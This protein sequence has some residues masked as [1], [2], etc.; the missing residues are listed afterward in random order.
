MVKVL[1][2][3][4]FKNKASNP[5]NYLLYKGIEKEG[6]DVQEFSFKRL[7]LMRYDIV[8]I[9]WP[10]LYLNSHYLSKAILYNVMLILGL[11]L[12]KCFNK[13]TVWTVHNLK[14]HKIKYQR[15]NKLFWRCYL[16]LVDSVISLSKSNE[17]LF[18]EKFS[19]K[20]KLNS[21]VVY[22]GLY[23]GYYENNISKDDAK[24]HFA[25]DPSSKVCLF[26]GQVKAY[27]NVEALVDI[28]NQNK[29]KDTVLII[30]GKFESAEYYNKVKALADSN[31]NI[32][33]NN[34]FIFDNELQHYFNAA[35]LCVLPFKDIFNSGSVLLSA[36]FNTPVLVPYSDNFM[37]YAE[38]I[39]DN[40]IATYS[41]DINENLITE[42]L[43]ATS[44]LLKNNENKLLWCEVQKELS[45]Y[46]KSIS[47]SSKND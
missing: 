1:A 39:G 29:L 44:K 31:S 10:E 16:P 24:K 32:I 18:F 40:F 43:N 33:I 15:L 25:I 8:H 26:I 41:E 4:A 34:K 46:Y 5:Y 7:F 13:K 2:W 14:P 37:E 21:A 47:M 12:G 20:K 22:H 17:K 36:S 27:K 11:L 42:Q 38:L 28:F 3:P 35:D 6:V 45:D 23:E 9:H 30:A 19:F